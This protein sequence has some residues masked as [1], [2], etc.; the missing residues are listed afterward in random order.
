MG[1]LIRIPA[2]G[3]VIRRSFQAIEFGVQASRDLQRAARDGT[4][5]ENLKVIQQAFPAALRLVMPTLRA[6]PALADLHDA[7]GT[8]N[9]AKVPEALAELRRNFPQAHRHIQEIE[10]LSAQIEGSGPLRQAQLARR[11]LGPVIGM[12]TAAHPLVELFAPRQG[13]AE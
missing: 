5:Q 3:E 13:T 8:E 1:A 10:A 11:L 9:V 7:I 2:P 12:L 4:L 6:L